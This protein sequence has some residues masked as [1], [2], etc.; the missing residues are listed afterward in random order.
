MYIFTILAVAVMCT[1]STT[2]VIRTREIHFHE[3][4]LDS[5]QGAWFPFNVGLLISSAIHSSF[6]WNKSASVAIFELFCK[7]QEFLERGLSPQRS[8]HTPWEDGFYL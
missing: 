7:W 1:K 2:V 6:I 8:E 3:L 4:Q 5:F